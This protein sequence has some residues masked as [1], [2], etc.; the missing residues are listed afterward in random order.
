MRPGSLICI[1]GP[2]GSGKSALLSAA[3]G[4]LIKSDGKLQI[5]V[6]CTVRRETMGL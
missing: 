5:N 1:V 4:D 2:G 6:S 3:A